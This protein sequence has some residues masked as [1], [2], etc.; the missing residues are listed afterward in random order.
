MTRRRYGERELR[1]R[2]IEQ[3]KESSC[4]EKSGKCGT[5]A[6]LLCGTLALSAM[7]M[8]FAK[9]QTT[10]HAKGDVAASGTW[11]LAVTVADLKVSSG[12]SVQGSSS[13]SLT[14]TGQKE[15]WEI[16]GRLTDAYTWLEDST[17]VG[18]QSGREPAI[19]IGDA[20]VIGRTDAEALQE[21]QVIAYWLRRQRS[22][23]TALRS[24]P[25]QLLAR[26]S[27]PREIITTR[28]TCRR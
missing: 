28:R 3:K 13:G 25:K 17:K 24:E 6:L 18:T 10:L 20:V 23:C 11:N 16:A 1:R 8:G 21:G 5:A 27:A 15:D 2:E 14:R 19:E 22:W 26:Y 12:A 4:N 9:W 7:G